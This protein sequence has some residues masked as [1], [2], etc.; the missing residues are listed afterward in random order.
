[1]ALCYHFRAMFLNMQKKSFTCVN[2]HYFMLMIMENP[3]EHIIAFFQ[4][5][6][7]QEHTH[8]SCVYV[9][10]LYVCGLCDYFCVWTN[11][12]FEHVKKS[13]PKPC[14]CEH[15]VRA[16]RLLLHKKLNNLLWY[17]GAI[18]VNV[19]LNPCVVW[20]YDSTRGETLN[21]LKNFYYVWTTTST[22]FTIVSCDS[23]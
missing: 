7:V 1:M 10:R 23:I 15:N 6:L 3:C 4:V 19:R 14:R 22:Y 9:N 12:C 13:A 5:P 11:V 18:C 16:L 20:I 17:Q 8:I 2:L 21:V